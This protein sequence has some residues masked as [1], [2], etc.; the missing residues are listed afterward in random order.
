MQVG[1][2]VRSDWQN[3]REQCPA[4]GG[5]GGVQN[6]SQSETVD[7][8]VVGAG[9]I[10]LSVAEEAARRGLSVLLVNRARAGSASP[11]AGGMLTPAAE[12]ETAEPLLL[13]LAKESCRVYPDWIGRLEADT[14]QS[15][16]YSVAGT[17]MLALHRDHR[18][19]LDHLAQAQK[20]LGLATEELSAQ[21]VLAL[22]PNLTPRQ[23]GALYASE[24]HFVDPRSLMAVLEAALQA[25]GVVRWDDCQVVDV[26]RSGG[27][28]TAVSVQRGEALQTV[29]TS[30][31][32][33][34]T[35]AWISDAFPELSTLAM[36]PVRG[37]FVLLK[38]E[39]LL[40]RV[41]RTPDIYLIPRADGQL[42]VG[43]TSEEVG[44]ESNVTAGGIMDV[45]G[46]SWRALPGIYELTVLETGFG[47]RPTLRDHLP[48]IGATET[49]GLFVAT[50][51]Y[52]HGVM[53]APLTATRIMDLITGASVSIEPA[54]DP[55]RFEALKGSAV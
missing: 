43:T 41:V 47:F 5:G 8:V 29:A 46:Y 16:G 35:G 36:R 55:L 33:V 11:A 10:G 48:A 24:D 13:D 38:G 4:D 54:L 26:E 44:F 19:D 21:Q 39:T 28:I 14:G 53:L 20:S 51:H 15:C 9:L 52:R 18:A 2:G 31:I 30:S 1:P 6:V 17:L 25:Q 22:E 32:V 37:Q 34:A 3:K 45:L 23:V 49:R 42:F 50:G 7:L 40:E 27:K 12:A